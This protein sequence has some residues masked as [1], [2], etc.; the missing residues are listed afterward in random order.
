MISMTLDEIAE[1]VGGRVVDGPGDLEVAGGPSRDS[2]EVEPG[3]LFVAI[4]GQRVDG[5]DF[6]VAA[7]A[8]GASA[9]LVSRSVGVP[10]VQVD[11]V[12]AALGRLA[13]HVVAALPHLTVIGLTGSQGKTTTKDLLALVLERFGET[14]APEGSLNNEIGVPL[15]ALRATSSTRYLVLEM[16]ARR[17]GH[18][19]YLTSIAPVSVGLVLNVGVAHLGEFGSRTEIAAAKGEL[20][21]GLPVGGLAVLNADD[22]E[23]AAMRGRTSAHVVTFGVSLAADVQISDVGLDDVGRVSFALAVGGVRAHLQL[24]LVG[25]HHAG[26]AAAVVAVTT[27][28]G[29]ALPG[30]LSVLD[31]ARPRSPWR[32]EV[33]ASVEGVTVI[34]D[35]YNANPDSMQAAVETLA[36]IGRRRGGPSRTFAVLGEMLELGPESVAAHVAVGR[37]AGRLGVSQLIV[38]GEGARAISVGAEQTGAGQQQPVLVG[39]VAEAIAYV[40]GAVQG[41]DVV[42]VKA[43]RAVGLERVALALLGDTTGAGT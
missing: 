31:G 9:A 4:D 17:R 35:A 7:V 10:A 27:G 12:V 8:A 11:D 24:G 39:D 34:N 33:E 25:E 30:V 32:M 20:V 1:V 6:A 18:I 29:L 15:T 16:G 40:Q 42:L 23:V 22:A 21:E 19:S 36:E 26:N 14:V 43:S 37:L 5:H 41:G 13:A 38:V 28:L 3:G 2:R